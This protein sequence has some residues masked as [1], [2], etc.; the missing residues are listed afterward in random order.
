MGVIVYGGLLMVSA[1]EQTLENRN[2]CV[3]VVFALKGK[4]ICFLEGRKW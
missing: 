3:L 1:M 4:G 2:G